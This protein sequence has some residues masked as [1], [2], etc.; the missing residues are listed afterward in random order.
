MGRIISVW[1]LVC[2]FKYL[3]VIA[4]MG[5]VM[6]YLDDNS[7]YERSLRWARI[8]QYKAEIADYKARY[9][10]DAACLRD[11]ESNPATVER[12]ARERYYLSRPNEDV[13]VIRRREADTLSL[14]LRI[15]N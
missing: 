7:Y 10:Y 1:A 5:I 13:F 2:R 8:S 15:E 6:G 3:V 14:K 12:L 11:L 9:E 4:I